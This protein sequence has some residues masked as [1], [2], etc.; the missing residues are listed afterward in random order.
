MNRIVLDNGSFTVDEIVA[1]TGG[2][3]IKNGG[4][5]ITSISTDSRDCTDGTLFVAIKG[6]RFDGHDFI[7]DTMNAGAVCALCERVPDN[8]SSLSGDLVIVENTISALGKIAHAYLERLSPSVVAVTGSVGKTTTK[9]F[10]YAVLNEKYNAHKTEGNFNN[11]LGLP[12]TVLSMKKDTNT[13]VFE[14]GMSFKGEISYLSK[15]ACPKIA[16]IT[17]IGNSHIENLGSRENICAAKLEITDGLDPDGYILLNADEPLLFA[18]K[19]LLDH[20]IL[21]ISMQNPAADFRALNVR[22]Y[23]SYSIYD[24]V[25]PNRVVTNIQIPT[26][27]IHN[28]HDS[29]FAFVCGLLMGMSDDEIKRGLMKFKNTGMRQN[30][31]EYG[32]VTIIEDCY[33]AGPES[34]KA[35]LD[36]LAKLSFKNG[37]RSI[38]VLGEMRELGEYSKQLHMEIGRAVASKNI[39]KL[40]TF[41]RDAENIVLGAINHGYLPER[42]GINGDIETPQTTANA[43]RTILK[44]GDVV[45]FKASRAVRLERVIEMLKKALDNSPLAEN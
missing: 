39:G 35:S 28:V 44:P 40:F 19:D 45:L 10:I 13:A 29:V 4:S 30:V 26:I 22:T 6:E 24:L 2:A 18:Q 11:E 27:G 33:N 9:E 25:L 20:K 23:D 43:L 3:V 38:A 31:Y 42:V 12:L 1:I 34:M 17:N 5:S 41:G 15:L 14:M 16:V 36:V 32:G 8:A 37:T 7:E 21:F